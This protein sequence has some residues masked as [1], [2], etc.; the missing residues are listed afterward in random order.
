MAKIFRIIFYVLLTLVT[1]Q[2]FSRSVRADLDFGV[3]YGVANLVL[4]G[5]F[6]RIYDISAIQNYARFPFLYPPSSALI[7]SPLALFSFETSK[8]LWSLLNALLVPIFFWLSWKLAKDFNA[9]AGYGVMLLVLVLTLDPL[10]LNAVQGNV[11][12]VVFFLGVLSVFLAHRNQSI[13]SATS[14]SVAFCLKLTPLA[15]ILPL[16]VWRRWKTLAFF[17][18]FSFVLFVLFPIL[19]FGSEVFVTLLRQWNSSLLDNPF[20]SYAKYTNQSPLAI[21]R[22]IGLS[23]LLLISISFVLIAA[24]MHHAWRFKSAYAS[25][26]ASTVAILGLPAI[27][28]MEYHFL[29]IPWLIVIFSRL[30]DQPPSNRKL[31]MIG[32]IGMKILLA[33]IL[34]QSL[35]GREIALKSLDHGSVY[36]ALVF[37]SIGTLILIKGKDCRSSLH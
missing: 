1:V 21:A 9:K 12:M 29:L 8:I 31:W 27:V 36:F 32:S 30:K 35:V 17:S 15:F 28:W 33:N 7:L 26:V 18:A 24:F 3:F 25:F 16:I 20:V 19:I 10:T 2:C 14:L 23:P 37:L 5:D 6:L 34:V 22:K 13:L 11:N 4:T